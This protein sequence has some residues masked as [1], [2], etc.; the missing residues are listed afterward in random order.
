MELVCGL[1]P[2]FTSVL[3]WAAQVGCQMGPEPQ[4]PY[5]RLMESLGTLRWQQGA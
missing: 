5:R 3:Q 4:E 2:L 1:T